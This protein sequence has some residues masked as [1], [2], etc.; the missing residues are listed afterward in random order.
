MV[1]VVMVVDSSGAADAWSLANS[2]KTMD[3]DALVP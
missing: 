2:I 1:K 3:A